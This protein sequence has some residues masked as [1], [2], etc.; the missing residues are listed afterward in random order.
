MA[1]DSK[2]PF[3]NY[4]SAALPTELCRRSRIR[5]PFLASSSRVRRDRRT[6]A[7]LNGTSAE[8]FHARA[9]FGQFRTQ[10]LRNSVRICETHIGLTSY[11][12]D[13]S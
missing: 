1:K 10:K 11:C 9:G 12:A 8:L 5:K 13:L 2:T 4:K 3:S 7:L 6:H